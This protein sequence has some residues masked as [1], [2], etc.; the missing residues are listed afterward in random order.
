MKRF[1][2]LIRVCALIFFMLLSVCGIGIFGVAPILTKDKK[3]FA[4]M[5]VKSARSENDDTDLPAKNLD[6]LRKT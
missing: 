1:Q 2:R 4:D 3:L 5:V 6:T